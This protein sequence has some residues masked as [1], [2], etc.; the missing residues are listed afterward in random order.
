M[1]NFTEANALEV[2]A[3]RAGDRVIGSFVDAIT[4]DGA[5]EKLILWATNRSSAYVCIANVHMLTSARNDDSLRSALDQSDMTLADGMPIAWALSAV[6]RQRQERITGPDLMWRYLKVAEE[7]GHRVFFYGST[8]KTLNKLRSSLE[9]EFPKLLIAGTISPP[10]G[11]LTEDE[12][13]RHADTINCA[14]TNIVFVGLG[15]PKQEKWMKRQ[16]GRIAA[17][18]VGVGAAFDYHSGN[19]RRAP[20]WMQRSGMEWLYRLYQEPRRLWRRYLTSNS[21]FVFLACGQLLASSG[22]TSKRGQQ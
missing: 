2:P 14:G 19:L 3:C 8:V 18:M 21:V 17:P 4:L 15:C 1:P 22:K 11:A 20:N 7:H 9:A 12:E 10:F 5:I 6:M 16:K 13:R